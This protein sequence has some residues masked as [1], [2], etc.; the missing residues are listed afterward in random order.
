MWWTNMDIIYF[1]TD[2]WGWMRCCWRFLLKG[3]LSSHHGGFNPI[4]LLNYSTVGYSFKKKWDSQ[5]L[6]F[7]LNKTKHNNS[8][9]SSSLR[10]VLLFSLV[11]N[12]ELFIVVF[13]HKQHTRWLCGSVNNS[14]EKDTTICGTHMQSSTPET[15]IIPSSDLEQPLWC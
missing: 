6:Q 5:W 9:I 2:P 13:A 10:I 8:Q 7:C 12:P 15:E 1:I 11:K 14:S 4:S 3:H